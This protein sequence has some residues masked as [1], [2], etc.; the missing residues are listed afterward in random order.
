MSINICNLVC[1]SVVG[2]DCNVGLHDHKSYKVCVYMI[3]KLFS[4]LSYIFEFY[5]TIFYRFKLYLAL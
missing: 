1:V 2:D 5:T 4:L 3:N